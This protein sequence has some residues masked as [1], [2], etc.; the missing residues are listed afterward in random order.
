MIVCAIFQLAGVNVTEEVLT[1]PSVVSELLIGIVT[2]AVGWLSS[3]RVK[4]SV[5][6]ASV[7]ISPPGGTPPVV[8]PAVSLSLFVP[9]IFDGFNPL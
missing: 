8:M 3:T 6:P 7:V 1:V 2:L 9:V 4:V 5:P